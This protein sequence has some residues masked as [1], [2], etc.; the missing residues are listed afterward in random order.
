MSNLDLLNYYET[1]LGLG[2]RCSCHGD[3]LHIL[4]DQVI[5]TT[6]VSY[7]IWFERKL[8]HEQDNIILQ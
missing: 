8:K 1:K 6:V 4:D 2:K 5:C 7:L 3:C